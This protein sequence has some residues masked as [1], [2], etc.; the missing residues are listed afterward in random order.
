M[1]G[2]RHQSSLRSVLVA[3]CALVFSGACVTC[4]I[5][6]SAL[7]LKPSGPGHRTE[8]WHGGHYPGALRAVPACQ[9][10]GLPGERR[11]LPALPTEPYSNGN[12]DADVGVPDAG[13]TLAT[14]AGPLIR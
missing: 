12:H 6:A 10:S 3:I 14:P 7:R 8:S 4:V 13:V 5:H 1:A 11:A 2:W 9:T